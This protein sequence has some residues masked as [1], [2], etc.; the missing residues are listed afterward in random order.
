MTVA[1]VRFD[2]TSIFASPQKQL[3]DGTWLMLSQ[4]HHPRFTIGSPIVIAPDELMGITGEE[5]AAQMAKEQLTSNQGNSMATSHEEI[6]GLVSLT[7][8]IS[9]LKALA[10]DAA[11]KFKGSV[12]NLNDAVTTTHTVS[13]SLDKAASDIRDALGVKTNGPAVT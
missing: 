3:P 1:V 10:S 4:S 6:D 11:K 5:L 2:G 9:S 12:S 7:Q 8:T 13:E